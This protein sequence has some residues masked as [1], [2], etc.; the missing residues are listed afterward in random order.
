MSWQIALACWA[1]RKH[2]RPH[3]AKPEVDVELARRY[4]SRRIWSPRVPK[5][6]R[7][8]IRDRSA[9]APLRGEWLMPARDAVIGRLHSHSRQ[10]RT[11][12]SSLSTI[13]SHRSTV[14]LR[15]STTAS[16]YTVA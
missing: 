16:R 11:R 6:W 7:L 5:G 8:D 4:A 15:Q 2:V 12:P 9:D 3:T 13:A 10:G 1:V 14:F